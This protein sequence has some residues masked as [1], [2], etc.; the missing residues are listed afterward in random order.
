RRGLAPVRRRLVEGFVS[1]WLQDALLL[2]V[3]E[4]AVPV[5]ALDAERVDGP[6]GLPPRSPL[7][8]GVPRGPS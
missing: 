6:P 2:A 8:P 5:W 7:T 4:T 1:R 3:L